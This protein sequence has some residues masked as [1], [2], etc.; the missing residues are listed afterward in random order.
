MK[1]NM[2]VA[3][4]VPIKRA[5]D[6]VSF[7]LKLCNLS[8]KPWKFASHNLVLVSKRSIIISHSSSVVCSSSGL[9]Q[10]IQYFIV[11]N[12]LY[13]LRRYEVRHK[14]WIIF[15]I[16][17]GTFYRWRMPDHYLN[18]EALVLSRRIDQCMFLDL[19]RFRV[20]YR[21]SGFSY[22]LLLEIISVRLAR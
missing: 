10:Y 21:S 5:N 13:R 8:T 14:F 7:Y 16:F 1:N 6:I 18:D 12:L 20:R 17:W 15:E 4:R 9:P 19:I 22:Y 11:L 3:V 2:R